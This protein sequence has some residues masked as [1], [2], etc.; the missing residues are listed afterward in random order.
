MKISGF[1]GIEDGNDESLLMVSYTEDG[2]QTF[3]SRKIRL[4]DFID[5]FDVENLANVDG[6]PV[7]GQVLRFSDGTWSPVDVGDARNLAFDDLI[8]VDV[9]DVTDGQYLRYQNGQWENVNVTIPAPVMA[10]DDLTDVE[11]AGATDGQILQLSGGTWIAKDVEDVVTIPE[12]PEPSLAF[13]DLTDVAV[14]GVTNGQFLQFRQNI[15][16]NVTVTLPTP[17]ETL[18]DLTDV[19]LT[20]E[21]DGEFLQRTNGQWVN[22]PLTIPEP[23][24]ALNDITDVE[25]D[26]VEENQI[27]QWNGAAWVP[28]DFENAG[29]SNLTWRFRRNRNPAPGDGRF[30]LNGFAPAQSNLLYVDPITDSG[31]DVAAFINNFVVAGQRLF[32][33]EQDVD[34]NYAAFDIAGAPLPNSESIAIPVTN[35]DSSQFTNGALCTFQFTSVIA[36]GS[37]SKMETQIAE[38]KARLDAAGL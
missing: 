26:E 15:W 31:R 38:L 16:Q 13:D 17:P 20:N 33:Q 18:D 11:V 32:I 30:T 1:E 29:L 35:V 6:E 36:Q 14:A 28:T 12:P 22:T 7:D 23:I 5:D 27:L 2:G 21:A 19:T 10:F 3:K 4:E 37:V 24:L 9:A 25:A 8:D 34:A